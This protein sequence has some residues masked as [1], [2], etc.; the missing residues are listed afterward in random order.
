MPEEDI[1]FQDFAFRD[2]HSRLE[3]NNWNEEGIHRTRKASE[4]RNIDRGH[5]LVTL[6]NETRH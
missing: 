1:L 2:Q 3:I 5:L 6:T 4:G